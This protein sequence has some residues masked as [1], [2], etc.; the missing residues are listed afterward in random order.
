MYEA[1]GPA[2][3]A[4]LIEC[5]TDNRNRAVSDVRVAV[6]R[7]G[8]TMADG[9]SVQR[10]FQRKGV[11]SVSKT[12]EV[13]EGR[14]TETREVDE[15]QL[16]EAT[17]DAEPEDI[18][19]EGEVFEIISDPNAVVDVRKAVQDAGIDYD[20]A[21]VSFKPDFTQ[22]V[23]LDGARKLYKILDAL[24]DLDDV[25]NVFS[26]ADIPAEVAAALDGEE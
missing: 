12:Y 16:M 18:V 22:A 14:K 8:G 5:L 21:E 13:E 7:N 4:I 10:L 26:N 23:D 15:D 6:T 25:Q 9:G 24:E 19:D 20:S 1:Y 2:G 3:V 17:I 11:V